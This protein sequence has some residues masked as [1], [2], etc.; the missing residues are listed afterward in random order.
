VDNIDDLPVDSHLLLGL[1]APRA[2]LL[3]M[4]NYDHAADPKGEFLA[5]VA[6]SP[7]FELLRSSGLGVSK[8]AWPLLATP[9]L[10]SMAYYMHEGGHGTQPGD[11]DV[12]LDFLEKHLQGDD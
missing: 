10:N 6:A 9:V 11:W 5:A 2:V 8:T 3:Q 1:I 12:F 7:I 4:G